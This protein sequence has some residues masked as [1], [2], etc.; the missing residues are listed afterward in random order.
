MPAFA[1]Q[2][3]CSNAFWCNFT[4]LCKRPPEMSTPRK[5]RRGQAL[6]DSA[7]KDV[8]LLILESEKRL[9]DKL[10]AMVNRIGLLANKVDSISQSHPL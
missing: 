2:N 1:D 8:K 5:T 3:Q 4:V 7:G 6:D 10:D 9:S